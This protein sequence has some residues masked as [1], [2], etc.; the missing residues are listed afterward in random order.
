MP[1]GA[2][3]AFQIIVAWIAN[4]FIRPMVKRSSAIAICNMIGNCAS[5]W[6]SYIY[7]S[8]TAPQY[9]L[10]GSINASICV[11]V[12]LLALALRVIHKR[13]NR[14]LDRAEQADF[15]VNDGVGVGGGETGGTEEK[16]RGFRYVY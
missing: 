8:S 3:P 9:V 10:G 7:P 15:V 4:S 6:G 12:A 14:K 11:V 2:V 1:I 5:I 13:E 16:K